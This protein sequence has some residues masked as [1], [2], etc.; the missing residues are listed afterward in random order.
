MNDPSPPASEPTPPPRKRLNTFQLL[1]LIMAAV[2]GVRRT[3]DRAG[4]VSDAS[5]SA[6]LGAVLVF[7]VLGALAMWGFV[8]AV[9]HAAGM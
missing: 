6:I 9:K 7:V 2:I 4:G 3:S 5:T 1:G 8:R